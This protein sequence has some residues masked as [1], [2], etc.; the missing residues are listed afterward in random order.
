MSDIQAAVHGNAHPAPDIEELPPAMVEFALGLGRSLG[1]AR[2]LLRL[3]REVDLAGFENGVGLLC[4]KSL[5]LPPGQ[6]RGMRP[7]LIRLRDQLDRLS[8]AMC[9][10]SSN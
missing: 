2:A 1:V 4:A 7:Y 9:G 8:V 5:D 3:G 10:A 6:A